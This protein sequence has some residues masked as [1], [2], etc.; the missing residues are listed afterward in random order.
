MLAYRRRR[1]ANIKSAQDE[2]LVFFWDIQWSLKELTERKAGVLLRPERT[3][4][5]PGKGWLSFRQGQIIPELAAPRRSDCIRPAS[6]L[7]GS[8]LVRR[9]RRK[10]VPIHIGGLITFLRWVIVKQL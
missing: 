6:A 9:E 10:Q 7:T 1:R 2:R 4:V 8:Y 3:A 5:D